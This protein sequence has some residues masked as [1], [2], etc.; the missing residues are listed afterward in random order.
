MAKSTVDNTKLLGFDRK[1]EPLFDIVVPVSEDVNETRAVG[2]P[3]GGIKPVGGGK[4]VGDVKPGG[5]AK[6]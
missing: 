1:G 3:K 2:A 4:N 6:G 5:A